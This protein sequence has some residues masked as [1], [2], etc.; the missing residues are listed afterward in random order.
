M[1]EDVTK[2]VANLLHP[3]KRDKTDLLILDSLTHMASEVVTDGLATRAR[4]LDTMFRC[5][6][7]QTAVVVTC[8]LR[9]DDRFSTP[10]QTNHRASVVL[11]I[12]KG[13]PL[14]QVNL[15][16]YRDGLAG[17]S[18]DIRPDDMQDFD[19]SVILTRYERI[20]RGRN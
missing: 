9:R 1:L 18:C 19:R 6:F 7:G 3:G 13:G 5:D 14:Y 16:K 10:N 2:L 15:V 20:L 8:Q 4:Q 17:V 11:G 12:S